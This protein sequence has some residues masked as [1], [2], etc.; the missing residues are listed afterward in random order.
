MSDTL[1]LIRSR[2][3]PARPSTEVVVADEAGSDE[4]SCPAFG[5]LRGIRDRALSIEFRFA[6]GN[7]QAFPYSWLGPM[8]YNPSAGLLLKFVGDMI[9]LVLIEG[10]NLNA[11]V[12]GA[13]SLYDRGVQRHR[14][15]WVREMTPQ[16]AELA[17][18]GDV[19]IDRIYVVSYRVDEEPKKPEW[20][21]R[22]NAGIGLHE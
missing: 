17:Q 2:S 10:S 8:N 21:E 13:V 6:N 14:V 4:D 22:V 15:S 12:G 5:F 16:Q 1:E 20:L 9:Y 19:V 7:S 18:P 11:L 3:N